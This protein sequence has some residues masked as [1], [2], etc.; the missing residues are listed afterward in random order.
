MAEAPATSEPEAIRGA[1]IRQAFRLEW[2]TIGWMIVEAAVAVGSGIAAHSLTLIAF[3]IDSVIE[4]ASACILVWRLTI[5]LKQG[6]KF[7]EYAEAKARQTAGLLLFV[8]AAYVVLSASWGL[9]QHRGSEFSLPGLILAV[10]AVP[11]MYWLYRSKLRL[12]TKLR[13]GALRAD[14]IESLA[15][16]WLSLVVVA[17]L[18][19]QLILGAWWLDSVTSL[20]IVYFL[21]KEGREAWE[22]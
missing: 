13:S 9:W 17:G 2:I 12:A 21:I 10:L 19:A 3:G 7:S 20:A 22:K 15:C 16:C 8:L 6:Q 11:T 5:E 1:H 14:A 18:T 4:L